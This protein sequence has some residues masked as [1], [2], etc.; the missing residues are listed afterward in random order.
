MTTI[1]AEDLD[2][3]IEKEWQY[4]DS[5]RDEWSLFEGKQDME[6]L[7]HILRCI[8]HLDRT[9]ELG[10]E[11]LE[12]VKVQNPDGGWSKQSHDDLTS[13]WITKCRPP[14]GRAGRI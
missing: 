12:C 13:M 10:D 5:K 11:F 1:I 8:L 7:E 9:Q 2:Q 14:P 6:V 3:L 4:L